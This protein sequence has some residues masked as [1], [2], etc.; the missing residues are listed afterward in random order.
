VV[1]ADGVMVGDRAAAGEDHLGRGR[2]DLL[3]LG[4]L[5]AAPGGRQHREVRRRAVRI[6]VREPARDGPVTSERLPRAFAYRP[7]ELVEAIPGHCGLERL[8]EDPGC[9]EG[10]AQVGHLKEG[11]APGGLR[12][13]APARARR[14]GVAA[15][16]RRAAIGRRPLL[17]TAAV[18]LAQLERAGHP[19]L[20]LVVRRLEA[21][22]QQGA[23]VRRGPGERRLARVQQPAVRRVEAGLRQGAHRLR[24]GLERVEP[25]GR[26]LPEARR[27]LDTHPGLGDHAEDPLGADQHAVGARPGS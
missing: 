1:A 6:D 8:G 22:H 3:P 16:P 21:Q 18:V 14:G 5:V 2:L 17:R 11:V 26:G 27:V 13:A 25:D 15:R 10:V 24:T 9:D 23:S 20:E 12:V 7:D 4:Q 19:W